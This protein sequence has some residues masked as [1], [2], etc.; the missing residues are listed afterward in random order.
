MKTG[1]KLTL[2]MVCVAALCAG[3]GI[4]PDLAKAEWET[5]NWKNDSAY[6]YQVISPSRTRL[7]DVFT[8]W[9]VTSNR[10]I[11]RSTKTF[12]AVGNFCVHTVTKNSQSITSGWNG[13]DP[14]QHVILQCP[15]GEVPEWSRG[16]IW[17]P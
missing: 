2:L 13:P 1:T 4:N 11:A 9:T 5:H 7:I 6:E 3:V 15:S 10:T 14:G 16:W 8:Q 17:A 12:H